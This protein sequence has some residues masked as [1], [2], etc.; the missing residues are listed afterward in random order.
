MDTAEREVELGQ[1]LKFKKNVTQSVRLVLST[2]NYS[3]YFHARG[4]DKKM[5]IPCVIPHLFC[6]EQNV[7]IREVAPW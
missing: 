2:T 1:I 7:T 3:T 4:I 6:E 5:D